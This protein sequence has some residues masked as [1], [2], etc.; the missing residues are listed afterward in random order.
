MILHQ[1]YN[2]N[3]LNYCSL[4]F[5]PNESR[6]FL[7]V[8]VGST[9]TH[10]YIASGSGKFTWTPEDNTEEILDSYDVEAGQLIDVR[11]TVGQL[12]LIGADDAGLSIMAFNPLFYDK[13]ITND[14]V[15]I[16]KGPNNKTVVGED[17]SRIVVICVDGKITINDKEL[18]SLQHAMVYPGKTADITI[19]DN[20]VIAIITSVLP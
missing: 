14:T 6:S 4:Y 13:D 11:E 5:G 9:H 8:G 2:T 19:P 15:E 16:V 20:S 3:I 12:Q 10:I 1:A 18:V 17:K 7:N